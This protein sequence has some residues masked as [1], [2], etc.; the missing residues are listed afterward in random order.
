[1]CIAI[2]A[3]S[4]IGVN[5]SS[6]A[7]IT[8]T[9][10]LS[11]DK[12]IIS[13]ISGVAWVG[14]RDEGFCR[15]REEGVPDL[16]FKVVNI[17]LPQG[18]E[19]DRYTFTCTNRTLLR[20]NTRVETVPALM[21]TDG[22]KGHAQPDGD[23]ASPSVFGSY[24]G[25]GYSHGYA[26]ASFAVY[27]LHYD[28]GRITLNE[29]VVLRLSTCETA[30][31][32][33][34]ATR[35]RHRPFLEEKTRRQI[36]SLVLNPDMLDGHVFERIRSD[37]V[38]RGFRPTAAP[39]LEGSPVDY[40][41]VTNEE[42]S[43]EFQRLA[44]WKIRKGVRTVIRTT[45]WIQ[46]H[47]RNG[48]DLAETIRFFLRD[49]YEKWG[50]QWV[51]L[52][53][54]TDVI[55]IRYAY[56]TFLVEVS[57][58][59]TDLYYACLD[60]SWNESHDN[61]W[62]EAGA[63][64]ADLYAELY[65]GRLPASTVSDAGV[66][67]DKI[68]VYESAADRDY[69]DKVLLLAEVLF[70]NEGG[71]IV[72]DGAALSESLYVATFADKPLRV[73][74]AYESYNLHSGS[75]PLSRQATIDSM[76]AGAGIVNHIGHGYRFNMSCGDASVVTGDADALTN[77][78][79]LFVLFMADCFVSAIDYKCLAE[80]FMINPNGGAV[81]TIGASHKE[82]P[83]VD[84]Y[85]MNDFY[86]LL[87]D[88]R[89]ARIGEA[90]ARS[91]LAQT[92]WA[93]MGNN[94]DLWTHYVYTLLSDPELAVWTDTVDSVVVSHVSSV[95]LGPNGILVEVSADGAPVDSA[96]VCLY[97][98]N[99]DFQYGATDAL[100][101]VVVDFAAESPGSI[102]VVVTG[103]NIARSEGYIVVNPS[104]PAY[105]HYVGAAADDDT[106]DGSFGNGDGVVDAGETVDLMLTLVNTGASPTGDVSFVVECDHPA[107]TV[108]DDTASVGVIEPDS[109]ATAQGAVR[110]VF[111]AGIP[112]ETTVEFRLEVTDDGGGSWTDTFNKI[113]HAPELVLTTLRIDDDPPLGNGNGVNEAGE[114][115]L[116]F[117]GVRNYGTGA[118]SG[119]TT[120]LAD[121]EDAFVF[122]DSTDT[123][124]D[125]QPFTGGENVTGFHIVEGET[126]AEHLLAVE[127]IDLL[128][129]AYRDTIELR[130]PS[131][132]ASLTFD[133]SHGVDRIEICWSQ[134]T[135]PGVSKYNVYRSPVSGGP[136]DLAT[137]DPVDHAVFMDVGLLPS[138][139]YYY[140]VSAIDNSGNESAFSPEYSASTNPPQAAGWPIEMMIS[141]TSSPA[142]GD[143]DGDGD[144]EIVVGNQ[145]VYAWHHDGTEVCDGDQNP[146][147][148]GILS[149]AGDV[150]TGAITLARLDGIPG[151]DIVAADIFTK[152]VYCMNHNGEQLPGWPRGG[153]N[154]FR[155]AP[156]AGDLDGDGVFEIVA[157]DT[158]GVIYAW[159]VDGSEVIDGDSDPLT[160]GVFFRTPATIVH[161]HTPALCDIDADGRDEIVLGTRAGAIYALNGDGSDV[162]GWPFTFSGE[163]AGSVSVGDVDDDG[164]PEIVCHG[165]S[166]KVYL[167]NHDGTVAS[168]WPRNVAIDQPYFCPSPAL[169]DF[170]G[171]GPLEIVV[172]GYMAAATRLYVIKENAQI[173]PGWPVQ[174]N[175]SVSAECSPTVADID[176]DGSLDI[177]VG[178]ESR[179][180]YAFDIN[181]SMLDGFPVATKD[182]VRATPFLDDVDKDGDIDMILA[183][184]DKN[185][186][187][188]DLTGV[189][190]R[191]LA[192][193][194]T[195]R[196]NVHRNGEKD[197]DVPT[198][199]GG[200]STRPS[201][202]PISTPR[203]VQNRPNP[204][205]LATTISFYVTDGAPKSVSLK[206]YDVSG[207]LVATLVDGTL[208]PGRHD[209]LW[210]GKD[211]RGKRVATG[212]YFYRLRERDFVST[213]KL[214]L[215][216]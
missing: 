123:Y 61:N 94:V 171:D 13:E 206:I 23:Y 10:S 120:Q 11:K 165:R 154:D 15:T 179:Y 199:V 124:P 190:D 200:I 101:E 99:E 163:T 107:T 85:Y 207:A 197:Y 59:P 41:I 193:W 196:A 67:I 6:A 19:I 153:E 192:P 115:F 173:Y 52:G 84:A 137:I 1:L 88:Q 142:V 79:R 21:T 136:Y 81:A 64:D 45:S 140:V 3:P 60:G 108:V 62:G 126:T 177:V 22:T 152:S 38:D 106:A 27:P 183:G 170:D 20:E 175:T 26:I 83:V 56:S 40:L 36:S 185:L 138:T 128:G 76:N 168:G 73:A 188:W 125:L 155:A 166:G 71:D 118:A 141:T 204:F 55:P 211:D 96:I 186:Y 98:P 159:N 14:V 4:G 80:H 130:P 132:P 216:R 202:K 162:P 47:C 75:V 195:F 148:W 114:E 198:G 97:K 12:V 181:G 82:F 9:F 112:D 147:T 33:D 131:P 176:G 91:R 2:L 70:R 66:L 63:D 109:T 30:R 150:F 54:D 104:T 116:L 145:Y 32:N 7:E 151:L 58:V 169:A 69:S 87:F 39:S 42:L 24:L 111:D 135:D 68:M 143:I 49:A 180:L 134:S 17:L 57:Y 167:L 157:V 103:H 74:R 51:L 53:G 158:R 25:T 187:V 215:V 156:V 93:E 28:D 122:I 44:D 178:D 214:L 161:Y 16:P 172:V 92:P 146:E 89:V 5:A 212:L 43:E 31:D 209:V 174:F 189:Y 105:V 90:F 119:L 203:L 164:A 35:E 133:A 78:N 65:V 210:E 46:Q 194:P 149:T 77:Q 127:T 110:V 50:T 205:G 72:L 34:V 18:H 144:K 102:S 184:W 113:V 8:Q 160:T 29:H 139:R 213:R 95:G 121:V 48:V 37:P 182:A 100:G 208:P 129:R 201:D 191:S 117:Y 86:E